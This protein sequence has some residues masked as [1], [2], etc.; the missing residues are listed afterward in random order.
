MLPMQ[1]HNARCSARAE[2]C[3]QSAENGIG[4]A[5]RSHVWAGVACEPEDKNKNKNGAMLSPCFTPTEQG[6]VCSSFPILTLI[7]ASSCSAQ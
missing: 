7:S 1:P 6:V 5:R 3:V 4:A 2:I